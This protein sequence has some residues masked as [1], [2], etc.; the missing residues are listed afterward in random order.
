MLEVKIK[1]PDANMD[2][3]LTLR[4]RD[5]DGEHVDLQQLLRFLTEVARVAGF[6]YVE[7]LAAMTIREV[8]RGLES[9]HIW[10]EGL[11]GKAAVDR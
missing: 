7:D 2:A 11:S 9:R 1:R 6:P 4:D 3:T 5:E 8:V 10:N